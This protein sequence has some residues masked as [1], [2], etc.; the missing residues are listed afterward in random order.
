MKRDMALIRQMVLA[1]EDF[2]S[3]FAPRT[4]NI[5]GYTKEQVSYHAH[6]MIQAGLAEGSDTMH[7][8]SS[9]PEAILRKLTWEGL[10][11]ADAAR[12]ETRWKKAIGL[13]QDKSG[14]VTMGALTQVLVGLMKSTLGL[15]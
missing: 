10:E 6:L 8:G 9:S 5:E 13:V 11:F 3:G 4:L 12:D 15:P 14:S 1:I 7:M 2:P